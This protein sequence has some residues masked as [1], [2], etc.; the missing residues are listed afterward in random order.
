MEDDQKQLKKAEEQKRLKRQTTNKIRIKKLRI[1]MFCL[2]AKDDP[3][4]DDFNG[5]LPK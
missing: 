1:K 5:R 3:N 2:I 4:E